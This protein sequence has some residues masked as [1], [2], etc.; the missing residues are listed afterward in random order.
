MI[1]LAPANGVG[2]GAAVE[3][4]HA[5][6]V[7]DRR[8]ELVVQPRRP[9]PPAPAAAR[10][11]RPGRSC[12]TGPAMSTGDAAEPHLGGRP[13]HGLGADA[14]LAPDGLEL[15][16]LPAVVAASELDVELGGPAEHEGGLVVG[17]PV[18][19]HASSA[20]FSRK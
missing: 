9:A 17:Q 7:A 2:V 16:E 13:P 6:P 3:H 5:G 10:P 12:T 8:E 18:V 15:G 14:D 19:G 20:S 1:T 11:A 4:G